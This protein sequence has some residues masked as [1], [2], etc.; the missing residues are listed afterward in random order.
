MIPFIFM[1]TMIVFLLLIFAFVI[2]DYTTGVLSSMAMIIVGVYIL[3]NGMEGI[4]NLLTISLG[5]IYVCIGM[6]ILIGGSLQQIQK[7]LG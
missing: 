4:V 6:Y 2:R 7:H 1:I 5:V 3:A